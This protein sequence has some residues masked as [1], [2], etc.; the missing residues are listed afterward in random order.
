MSRADNSFTNIQANKP[1]KKK[2]KKMRSL[3]EKNPF[4]ATLE[5]IKKEIGVH[6]ITPEQFWSMQQDV[7]NISNYR[8]VFRLL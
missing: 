6:E 7:S 3:A 2:K 8:T 5:C 4:I 1:N